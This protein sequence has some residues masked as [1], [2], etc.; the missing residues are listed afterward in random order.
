[1]TIAMAGGHSSD[2]PVQGQRVAMTSPRRKADAVRHSVRRDNAVELGEGPLSGVPADLGDFARAQAGQLLRVAR[3]LTR[4]SHDAEDLAQETL[5]RL[6]RNWGKVQAARSPTAYVRRV[7]VNAHL[8]ASRRSQ[9]RMTHSLESAG[10]HDP[11]L[12]QPDHNEATA[13]AITVARVL[14]ELP[15][16]QRTAVILRYYLRL[17]TPEIAA[18]MGIGPS[19]ARSLLSRAIAQLHDKLSDWNEDI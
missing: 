19:T 5:E 16:R 10:S 13:D 11:R 14:D 9:D 4:D 7:M 3:L 12:Q 15:I 18:A 17:S 6:H 8:D 2:M 1:M